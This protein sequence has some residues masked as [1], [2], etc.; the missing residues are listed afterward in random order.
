MKQSKYKIIIAIN[1]ICLVLLYACKKNY[2]EK[3]PLGSLSEITLANK[4]GVEGLLIGAYSLLDGVGQTG[5][6]DPYYTPD[7]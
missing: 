3:P 2:L 1:L 7:K 6:G 5:T 4:A